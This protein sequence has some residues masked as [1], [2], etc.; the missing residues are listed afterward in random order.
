MEAPSGL[1]R[2]GLFDQDAGHLRAREAESVLAS[3]LLV[4]HFVSVMSNTSGVDM[5]KPSLV[6]HIN[7]DLCVENLALIGGHRS[8]LAVCLPIAGEKKEE[9]KGK[10]GALEALGLWAPCSCR[11]LALT[12]SQ[13]KCAFPRVED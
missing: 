1:S 9:H 4:L 10:R 2:G 3:F 12:S 11:F 5:A 13:V 8:S 6:V 7:I